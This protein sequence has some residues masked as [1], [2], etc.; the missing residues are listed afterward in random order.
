MFAFFFYYC[1]IG[2]QFRAVVISTVR[3]QKTINKKGHDPDTQYYL[4]FLSDMRQLNTAFTRSQS[5][6]VV[7]GNPVALCSIGECCNVWK[8]YIKE[9]EREGSLYPQGTAYEDIRLEISAATT[10]LDPNAVSFIPQGYASSIQ[11]YESQSVSGNVVKPIQGQNSDDQDLAGDESEDD[12]NFNTEDVIL[13]ALRR[14]LQNDR[15]RQEGDDEITSDDDTEDEMHVV[16]AE[17]I[18]MV[19]EDDHVRLIEVGDDEIPRVPDLETGELIPS[20]FHM[21][22]DGRCYAIPKVF[23]DEVSEITIANS[24]QRATAMDGDEVTVEILANDDQV[25]GN[26]EI[27][28]VNKVYGKVVNIDNRAVDYTDKKLVCLVDPYSNNLM[29]PVNRRLPKIFI[30]DPNK[31]KRTR[32]GKRT[33]GHLV[34]SICRLTKHGVQRTRDVIVSNKVRPHKLFQ[35]QW[36]FWKKG[37]N[38]P[39]GV[40]IGEL[41]AGDN[42]TDGLKILRQIYEVQPQDDTLALEEKYPLG[43]SIPAEEY[44]GRKDLRGQLVFTI[45]PPGSEDLDDALSVQQLQDGRYVVGVH[46]A[47]VS[48]F[49]ER[50]TLWDTKAR[51]TATSFYPAGE[52]P[53]HMLPP[54]LSTDLCSLKPGQDKLTLSAFLVFNEHGHHIPA[55]DRVVRSVVHSQIQLTY[56]EAEKIITDENYDHPGS[57]LRPYLHALSCLACSCRKERLGN[58]AYSQPGSSDVLSHPLAHILVEEMMILANET[59]ARVLLSKLPQCTPLRRQLPPP[60]DR[61]RDWKRN[62]HTVIDESSYLTHIK[63]TSQ[64]ILNDT[65]Q[66]EREDH[67]ATVN[68]MRNTWQSIR[69]CVT[70]EEIDIFRLAGL[71]CTDQYHPQLAAVQSALHRILF[72]GEYINSGDYATEKHVHSSLSKTGYTHFTSPIR[73]YIDIVVHRLLVA[74]LNRSKTLPRDEKDVTQICHNCNIRSF[75]ARE[76]EL[77]THALHVALGLKERPMRIHGFIE[78][79]T[80][81]NVQ[82]GFSHDGRVNEGLK[83]ASIGFSILKPFIKP[84]LE[85][86]KEAVMK[87][88]ERVYH[89]HGMPHLKPHDIRA[90]QASTRRVNLKIDISHRSL[91]NVPAQNWRCINAAIACQDWIEAKRQILAVESIIH[92]SNATRQALDSDELSGDTLVEDVTCE[93]DSD[94]KKKKHYVQFE[95]SFKVGNVAQVQLYPVFNRGLLSPNVQLYQMTPTLYFCIEHRSQPVQCLSSVADH[96]PTRNDIKTYKKTWLP[97]IDM[98]AAYDAVQQNETVVIHGVKIEWQ[99]HSAESLPAGSFTLKKKFCQDRCIELDHVNVS[100]RKQAYLCIRHTSAQTATSGVQDNER[101]QPMTFVAHAWTLDVE[102]TE[103]KDP[104]KADMV[105]LNIF[106]EVNQMS[107]PFPRVLRKSGRE[108]EECTVEI[109]PVCYPDRYVNFYTYVIS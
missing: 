71:V 72:N 3:T 27:K 54:R 88:K 91:I 66:C 70:D 74:I 86:D 77:K 75:A 83:K 48:Y 32:K 29:V 19:E 100:R 79:L 57:A 30:P 73:R 67:M 21:D 28:D 96:V 89:I 10:T 31:N 69:E 99:H 25:E 6:V 105:E 22:L 52:K 35:V 34:I 38:Y 76:Y 40:V 59:A 51:Q 97:L 95:H 87:W 65:T 102:A 78:V 82:L 108:P 8:K 5:L 37:Y 93:T 16:S 20:I 84:E 41:P 55:E 68:V 49:V 15:R 43:W 33:S 7:V 106:F 26:V 1:I 60:I 103:E 36:R 17:D 92:S 94:S 42:K 53:I 61:F 104:A 107:A 14:Q 18:R 2:K 24:T 85:D 64:S 90:N 98:M 44:R 58:A 50:G 11:P 12:I 45:D 46:I 101:E 62:N 4:G 80:D 23:T 13:Q 109:I 47:D 39:I 63:E 81:K 56:D 9:C